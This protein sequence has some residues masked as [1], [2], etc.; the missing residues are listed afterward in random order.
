MSFHVISCHAMPYHVSF[1]FSD[2]LSIKSGRREGQGGGVK[3]V[4]LGLRQ[5]KKREKKGN[6]PLP[7]PPTKFRLSAAASNQVWS[8]RTEAAPAGI[9]DI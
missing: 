9:V 8:S 7:S 4:F 2:K 1:D 6:Q 3:Y 5:D